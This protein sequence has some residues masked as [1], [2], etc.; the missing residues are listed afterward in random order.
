MLLVLDNFSSP[1]YH[2][3]TFEDAL[4][5]VFKLSSSNLSPLG[6]LV[7][8]GESLYESNAPKEDHKQDIIAFNQL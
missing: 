1:S 8:Q 7:R 3:L 2:I 6:L 4:G 5:S